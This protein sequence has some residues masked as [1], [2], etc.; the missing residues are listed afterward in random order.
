MYIFVSEWRFST[1]IASYCGLAITFL[2]IALSLVPSADLSSAL[3]YEMESC[4]RKALTLAGPSICRP[5]KRR[6]NHSGCLYHIDEHGNN[7][8]FVDVFTKLDMCRKHY[9]NAGLELA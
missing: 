9:I 8:R 1:P 5:Y 3:I 2:S 6:S 7:T 4:G